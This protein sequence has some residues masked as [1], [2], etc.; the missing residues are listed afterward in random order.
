MRAYFSIR[1]PRTM[2]HLA[3]VLVAL[4]A[5]LALFL[6]Q[7]VRDVSA[8]TP[9]CG[10]INANTIWDVAGSPYIVTCDV[11][12]ANGVTLTIEPNVSVNFDPGTSLLVNGTL[13]ADDCTLT[14]NASTPARGDWGHVLF[15][16]SSQDASFDVNGDYVAG[17][18]IAGC[19]VEWGG[20]GDGVNG[21]IEVD[22]A[23]P[24]IHLNTIRQNGDSGIHATGRSAATPVVLKENNVNNNTGSTAGGGVYVATGQVISNTIANN[25]ID[26]HDGGGVHASDSTL[27]GNVIVDNQVVAFIGGGRGGG[28][29]ATGSTLLNNT[30]NSNSTSPRDGG[31]GGGIYASGST[32]IGNTVNGNTA[33]RGVGSA[34]GGGIYADG[35]TVEDNVVHGNTV[36]NGSFSNPPVRGGGIY[37]SLGT[38][39][40]NDV[41]N[42]TLNG[43]GSAYGGGIYAAGSTTSDNLVAGNA[44]NAAPAFTGYGGGVYAQGGSLQDNT[45]RGNSATG[46]EGW[47]GGVY[48]DA[49][50]VQ[51]NEITTNNANLGGAVYSE[52]GSVTANV[53]LTNTTQ[54]SGTVYMAGGTASGNTI[55]GNIASYGGGLFGDGANLVGNTLLDNEATIAGGGVYALSGTV[56][57][58]TVNENVTQ[59]DGGGLYATG[60]TFSGNTFSGNDAPS[61]GHGSGAYLTGTVQFTYNSV[62]TNTAAGGSVGGLAVAAQPSELRYNNLHG[63]DPFDA[64]VVSPEDIDATLN[65]WGPSACTAIPGQIYDGDDL[66]GRGQLLYTPSLYSPTAL[67]QMSVPGNLS[68]THGDDDTV[69]LTWQPIPELPNV[70]CRQPDDGGPDLGYRVYYGTGDQCSFDGQ[71]LPAGASPLDVGQET[72]IT[73][74]GIA[75]ADSLHFAVTAYDYLGRE[76]PFSNQVSLFGDELNFFLPLIATLMLQ[77]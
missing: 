5:L 64:E 1:M 9:V 60:G 46:A 47:G 6:S 13:V 49:A 45:I 50:I 24:F 37:A 2:T 22:G 72:S 42:N 58:N 11:A 73:L 61:W 51:E 27:V 62:V 67:A 41:A 14:S 43:S 28:V 25:T 71:D 55:Q 15:T 74:T 66:P 35:G 17:S 48:S 23:S 53:V 63:N 65:Y 68:L 76:S 77:E 39:T 33:R 59:N 36:T 19:L 31:D 18:K 8:D 56:N 44:A 52:D 26:G 54:L 57:G 10:T 70:G 75:G 4:G 34:Y 38:V 40:G 7:P 16:A 21:A 29:Y 32:L 20:G 3:V 30:V 12:V 69:T